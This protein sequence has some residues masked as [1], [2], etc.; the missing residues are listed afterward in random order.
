L[1]KIIWL[2][3]K[4]KLGEL[5]PYELN[6]RVLTGSEYEDLKQSLEKFDLAEIPVIDHTNRIIAGHQR[7]S[8][9]SDLKG[10]DHE[11]DVRVPNRQ[12][13]DQEFKEYLI[14]SNKNTG[15]WDFEKLQSDFDLGD[16]LDWGF[17]EQDLALGSQDFELPKDT[18]EDALGKVKD[19]ATTKCPA[20][21]FEI[22]SH[23]G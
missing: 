9:L 23:H 21:G 7:I 12:L 13:S 17:T 10:L 3:E 20:C 18:N 8:I 15:K 11:I 16:L 6:P 5:I 1:Q 4:R 14:R 22:E 19:T 2:N